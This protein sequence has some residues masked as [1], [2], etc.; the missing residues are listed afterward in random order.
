MNFLKKL[1]DRFNILII[2]LTLMSFALVFKLAVLTIV[3]GD[4]YRNEAENKRLRKIYQTAPRGEIRDRNGEL[5]AG[6]QASFTVQILKDEIKAIKDKSKVNDILVNIYNL[7]EEDGALYKDEFPIELNTYIYTG[8]KE[9]LNG[10]E[11]PTNEIIE[12]IA[13]HNILG[14]LLD[15]YYVDQ[16]SKLNFKF[17]TANKIISAL[18]AKGMVIP[19]EAELKGEQVSIDFIEGKDIEAWKKDYNI[20]EAKTAKQSLILLVNN[21]E[22]VLNKLTD[23][24][25]S[26]KIIYDTLS[27]KNLIKDIK[28][29]EKSFKYDIEY[30]AQKKRMSE[31][32]DSISM[33][34]SAKDDFYN[35]V[36][37]TSIH[38]LLNMVDEKDG[39]LVVPGKILIEKINK[40]ENKD[41]KSPVDIKV[42][43]KNK[44]VTYTHK[45]K[46]KKDENPIDTLIKYSMENENILKEFISSDEIKA[47]AQKVVLNNGI[48]PRISIADWEYVA[49]ANKIGFL[50][51]YKLKKETSLDDIYTNILEHYEINPNLTKY[52][53]RGIMSLYDQLDRQGDRAY[54]PINLAYGIKDETVARIEEGFMSEAAVQVSIE[55]IRYYPKGEHAAHLLGYLGRISQEDEIQKYVKEKGYSPNDMIG[56][57]GVEQSF[58][59]YLKGIDGSKSVHVDAFGNTTK[60]LKEEKL[61]PGNNLYLTIDSKLQKVAEDSLKHTLEELQ[62]GGT[63]KSQWGDY[64]FPINRKKGRP[65]K[66]ATSGSVVALDVKTGEVLALANY[67]AYNPNLFST[68]ISS[69][70]WNNLFPED[71]RDVLAPRPLYNIAMQ[72]GI[73][74]G[75]IYKVVPALAAL[76]KGLS[77]TKT[78]NGLGY[79][80]IGI[81]RYGCWIWNSNRGSHGPENV[82][83]A[84]RDSCNYYFY[85]LVLGRNQRTGEGLG[86]RLDVEDIVDMSVKLGMN[87]KTGIEINIP[88]EFSGGVP[89]PTRKTETTKALMKRFLNSNIEKYS[90]KGKLEKD[91]Q[92]KVINEIL[93][94]TELPENLSRT[95]VIK[96]LK[97]MDIDGERILEGEKESLVDKLV[98]TYLIEA[99]W[100]ITDTLNISIGQGM[101]AYTP[102]Q[103]ANTLSTIVNGGYKNKVTTLK[104][105]TNHNDSKTI[106]EN[107]VETEKID[108]NNDE[109]LEHIKEGLRQVT[110]QG[111]ARAAFQNFPVQV[112]AKTGT[113]ENSAINPVTGESYDDYSWFIAY[114]P[115]EDPEIAVAVLLFQGGGG[116]NSSPIAREII[117]EYLGL[118]EE[119]DEEIETDEEEVEELDEVSD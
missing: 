31:Q 57:V 7:L 78:I 44:K 2:L 67:P 63:F 56:K 107:K 71:D 101:N 98:H 34:T 88:N 113:A 100:N 119:E 89:S 105:I 114:G 40:S 85:T 13:E 93:S 64:K 15:T 108:L 43:K 116:G 46:A 55:P 35:I 50:S 70:D 58:E 17:L 91:D 110:T 27:E 68:G 99:R 18:E 53:I 82:Y 84:L 29:E 111:T 102:L 51:K 21:D 3:E 25:I 23:N 9:S 42:D 10:K 74:P 54:E 72:T 12:I 73:Q 97:N 109:N 117:G 115:H 19:I 61:V 65:F 62:K 66:Y 87:D 69:T 45:D 118:A 103:M 37:E 24:A 59:E 106:V 112:G 90:V 16:G 92:Q 49:M 8:D 81:K 95:E 4:H 104:K 22:N 30:L 38:D 47:L 52:E 96:R 20:D 83:G 41:L 75:S 79:V 32:F 60:V 1:K 14:E 76:E 80:D 77:P 11:D 48:N 33:E 5:L 36:L 28:L 26:R 6:N 94:W 39:D 86:L